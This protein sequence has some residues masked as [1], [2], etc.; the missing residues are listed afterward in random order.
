M[1]HIL[2]LIFFKNII[3][4]IRLK[5]YMHELLMFLLYDVAVIG[6]G[7][8]DHYSRLP[9]LVYHHYVWLVSHHHFV[10]VRIY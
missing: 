3:T 7:Y 2:Y 4:N 10:H 6:N 8:V 9:L 1:N 5:K